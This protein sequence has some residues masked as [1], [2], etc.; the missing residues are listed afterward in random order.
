MKPLLLRRRRTEFFSDFAAREKLRC[1]AKMNIC[2][3]INFGIITEVR[4]YD[5]M[6][7]PTIPG[8]VFSCTHMDA[9]SSGDGTNNQTNSE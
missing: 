7:Y 8:L 3:Q 2:N 5:V 4:K 9:E 6:H 1:W